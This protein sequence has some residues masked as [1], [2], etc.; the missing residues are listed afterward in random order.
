[1]SPKIALVP[2]WI[3]KWASTD[4]MGKNAERTIEFSTNIGKKE[5]KHNY[6]LEG[7]KNYYSF[8]LEHILWGQKVDIISTM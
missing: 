1:M 5:N 2:K 7:R 6:A 3:M 8:L 4:I